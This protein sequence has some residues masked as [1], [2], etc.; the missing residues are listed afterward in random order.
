MNRYKRKQG[1]IEPGSLLII[2]FISV[3]LSGLSVYAFSSFDYYTKNV[4]ENQR[5]KEIKHLLYLVISDMQIM[6]NDEID[7]P[8]DPSILF[9]RS[10]YD[11]NELILKDVSSGYHID[12]MPDD[13]L[14]SSSI[15]EYLFLGESAISYIKHRDENGFSMT[16]A[17]LEQFIKRPVLASCTV[18]GWLNINEQKSFAFKEISATFNSTDTDVLFPV[19]NTMPMTNVNMIE[20]EILTPLLYSGFFGIEKVSAANERMIARF[21]FGPVDDTDISAV[22]KVPESSRLFTYLGGKTSFWELFFTI[23][24]VTVN[25]LIGGIPDKNNKSRMVKEY[26]LVDWS[27]SDGK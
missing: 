4:I 9:L 16:N 2:L 19:V 22:L 12:F 13:L 11:K 15:S 1:S 8:D 26:R 24:D 25:A 10:K 5:M 27:M 7:Y 18:L 23:H 6:V 14:A 21:G 20:P 3:L 17:A